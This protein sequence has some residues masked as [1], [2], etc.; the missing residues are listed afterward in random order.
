MH[1]VIVEAINFSPLYMFRSDNFGWLVP[2]SVLCQYG[3]QKNWIE[4]KLRFFVHYRIEIDR[5]AKIP[6]IFITH[7]ATRNFKYKIHKSNTKTNKEY[8][9]FKRMYIL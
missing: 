3:T 1:A 2:S 9:L 5:L 6:Y 8:I 4:L 7:A